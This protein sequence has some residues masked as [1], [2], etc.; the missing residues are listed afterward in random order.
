LA[1]VAYLLLSAGAAHADGKPVVPDLEDVAAGLT[2]TVHST[3]QDAGHRRNGNPGA[4][5]DRPV[6]AG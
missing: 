1:A 3:A 6:R 4:R 5:Q 2:P